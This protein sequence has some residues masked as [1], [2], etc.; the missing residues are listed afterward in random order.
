[1][2]DGEGLDRLVTDREGRLDRFRDYYVAVAGS[3]GMTL[4]NILLGGLFAL[5]GVGIAA[6][7][8]LDLRKWRYIRS[9]DPIAIRDAAHTSNPVEVEGRIRPVEEEE[10]L[11][12]PIM[13]KPCVAYEYTVEE[14]RRRRRRKGGS[15][16]TWRTVDSGKASVPFVLEDDSARAL[17]RPDGAS[18]SMG[19]ERTRRVDGESSLPPGMR[20]SGGV[21]SLGSITIGARPLRYTEK[22]LDV[23]GPGY[24]FGQA[25][26][27]PR[28]VDAEV[29]VGDGPDTPMFVISDASEGATARRLMLKGAGLVA[30]G[31]IFAVFGTA[32]LIG[33]A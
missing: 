12:S 25:T 16:T 8:G 10:V 33:L 27:N 23:D 14:R 20:N 3:T 26:V 6:W 11:E 28:G 13:G 21:L 4:E 9:G 31:A 24:V 22:R 30:F 7:G 17:I 5:V 18:L 15:R 1:M 19:T 2:D 29:E 32:L